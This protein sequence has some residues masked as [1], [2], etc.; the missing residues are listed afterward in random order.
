MLSLDE[1]FKR[2]KIRNL[3]IDPYGIC[4]AKCWFCPVKYKKVPDQSKQVMSPELLRKIL[5][6]MVEERQKEDGLVDKNFGVFYTSHYNEILLYPHFEELLKIAKELKLCFVILSNGI[7]LTPEKVDLIVKYKEVVNG[8]CL[9]IPAFEPEL[10]SKRSGINIKQYDKLISNI[11]YA[12]DNLPSKV[13][14]KV[15]TIII[16][17]M[18]N[19]SMNGIVA[20][21]DFPSDIDLDNEVLKQTQLARQLF[22]KLPINVN[23]DLRDRGG[24]IDN[25]FVNKTKEGKVVGCHNDGKIGG[26]PVG[27]IH[28]NA[29]GNAFLCCNDY[30][31]ETTFGDF[32][33]QELKD[34]WG[35]TEHQDKINNLQQTLCTKC[36]EAIYE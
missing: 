33:T 6:N 31:M 8:I 29:S 34:F 28:I 16:N 23:T 24:S 25:V 22:P 30:D 35:T 5:N 18:N 4:N 36:S 1:T 7:P 21:A 12:I 9:N 14:S 27:W 17:G 19:N 32:N 11:N 3:Q 13:N 10:W 15:F 2:H 20:G 26:R